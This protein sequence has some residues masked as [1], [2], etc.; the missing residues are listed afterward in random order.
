MDDL[1]QL[2]IRERLARFR[3][4]GADPGSLVHQ[5]AMAEVSELADELRERQIGPP[6]SLEWV[7]DPLLAK[8]PT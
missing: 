8:R 5:S 7:P 4:D 1:T 2:R 6:D 3:A